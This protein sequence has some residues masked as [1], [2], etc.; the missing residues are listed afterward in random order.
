M[1]E[2]SPSRKL[3]Y[4]FMAVLG[5]S[6]WF[7]LAYPFANHNESFVIVT[8][9]EQMD[10]SDVL[11]DRIY[12]VANYRPLG[13][14]VAWVG[15]HIG[16]GNS[17]AVQLFNYIVAAIAWLV[18]FFALREH[19][20]FSYAAFV[21]GGFLFPGYIYLFHLHGVF[22]SPLLLLLAVLFLLETRPLSAGVLWAAAF[23]A[24]VAAFFHPYA[25]PILVAALVGFTLER[26]REFGAFGRILGGVVLGAVTLLVVMVILPRHD[27]AL[28]S[29]EML[30]G[31]VT[32]YRM[33]EVNAAV[34]VVVAVLAVLT[35]WSY[36]VQAK[37]RWLVLIASLAG[38]ALALVLGLP[39][40]FVWIGVTLVKLVLMKKWWLVFVIGGTAMLPAPAASGS[41]TYAIF[42]IMSC[43]GALALSWGEAEA[44]LARWGDGLAIL[45]IATT[46]IV[47]ALF[48]SGV[49]IP[50]LS[51]VAHPIFAERERTFQLEEIVSW[52]VRS[53]YARYE[54]VLLNKSG[55]PRLAP[56][57]VERAHRPPTIQEYLSKYT[58]YKRQ[59]EALPGKTV[60]IGF[61]GEEVPGGTLLYSVD[62]QHAGQACVFLPPSPEGK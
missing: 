35:A 32:S 61:G 49:E 58:R 52:L 40:L 23:T 26:P 5:F 11:T 28:T 60:L 47:F 62:S 27:S 3:L 31:L 45:L 29:H 44:R 14:A 18:L 13:Q 19:R 41:P 8:Q 36:P 24:L 59:N 6:F 51:R 16:G 37:V 25:L 20:V 1:S 21:V 46:L 43:T 50:V 42:V 4:G 17:S 15:Y 30:S 12:P 54:P 2:F 9:L 22:Y 33:T 56:D 34:S 7:F 38:I 10:L 39:V 55:N 57:A 48:R 53:E